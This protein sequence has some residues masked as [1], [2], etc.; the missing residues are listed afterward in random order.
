M[1]FTIIVKFACILRRNFHNLQVATNLTKSP[2]K[3]RRNG[4][5]GSN[6]LSKLYLYNLSYGFFGRESRENLVV[7]RKLEPSSIS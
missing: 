2:V 4:L 1:L 6:V 5:G 7:V 3:Q